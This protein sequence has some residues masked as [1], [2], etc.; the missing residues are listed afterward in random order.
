MRILNH[1]LPGL[2]ETGEELI[3][4]PGRCH[5]LSLTALQ[6]TP[7]EKIPNLW[8]TT[9]DSPTVTS[10]IKLFCVQPGRVLP[11]EIIPLQFLGTLELSPWCTVHVFWDRWSFA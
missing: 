1:A 7:T 11:S 9:D 8:Y 6:Y 2:V 3:E 10:R 5:P 4:L